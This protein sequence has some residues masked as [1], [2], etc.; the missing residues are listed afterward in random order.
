MSVFL[1]E[2]AKERHNLWCF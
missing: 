2:K 1:S